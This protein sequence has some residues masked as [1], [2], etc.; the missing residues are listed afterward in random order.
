MKKVECQGDIIIIEEEKKKLFSSSTR[1]VTKKILI[2]DIE[3][4]SRQEAS[5][6]LNAIIIFLKDGTEEQLYNDECY[7][8]EKIYKYFIEQKNQKS[9]IKIEKFNVDTFEVTDV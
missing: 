2:N 3:K 7:D 5:G 9:E 6:L 8:L 1:L 4:I